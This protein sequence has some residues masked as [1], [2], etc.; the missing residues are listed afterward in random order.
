MGQYK[1]KAFLLENVRGLYTHDHG[2][3]FETIMQKLH[4]LGYGTYDLLL[5]SSDF[6]VPQTVSVYTYLEYWELSRR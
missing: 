1:P 3:T 4:D 5:N 6:G 2:R